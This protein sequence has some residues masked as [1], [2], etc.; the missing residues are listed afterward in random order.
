M[1]KKNILNESFFANYLWIYISLNQKKKIFQSFSLRVF[2]EHFQTLK[3]L[4]SLP[5]TVPYLIEEIIGVIVISGSQDFKTIFSL[6][7]FQRKMNLEI[8]PSYPTL[9]LIFLLDILI[10]LFILMITFES[11]KNDK[12]SIN[13]KNKKLS[14]S[15]LLKILWLDI[16]LAIILSNLP[17]QV[18]PFINQFFCINISDISYNDHY[19]SLSN[20]KIACYSWNHKI[21]KFMISLP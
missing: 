16:L 17:C 1:I 14:F 6:G 15:Q 13:K 8:S 4:I 5:F 21:I 19:F 9:L 20:M 18:R 11:I 7:C 10:H 12:R 2:N 3:L